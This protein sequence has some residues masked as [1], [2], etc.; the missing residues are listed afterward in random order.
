MRFFKKFQS[1]TYLFCLYNH[2]IK[3]EKYY[4]DNK[5][6][7][8]QTR[9]WYSALEKFDCLKI[10]KKMNFWDFSKNIKVLETKQ[11]TAMVTQIKKDSNLSFHPWIN[12]KKLF[13]RGGGTVGLGGFSGYYV[14]CGV[15]Q[16]YKSHLQV[17]LLIISIGKK[18]VWF[19]RVWIFFWKKKCLQVCSIPIFSIIRTLAVARAETKF[20]A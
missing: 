15:K 17:Y 14:E 18:K 16:P 13:G 1:M 11:F 9:R 10:L 6:A 5:W 7:S 8:D 2:N 19:Q 4:L 12:T 3:F 20:L